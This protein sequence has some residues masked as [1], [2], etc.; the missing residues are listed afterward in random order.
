MKTNVEQTRPIKANTKPKITWKSLLLF[1]V[2]FFG[3][4]IVFGLIAGIIQ[5]ITGKNVVDLLFTGNIALLIDA[6]MFLIVFG[7]FKNIRSFILEACSF[8]PF[9]KIKT[10]VYL[11]ISIFILMVSQFVLIEVLKV[12]DISTQPERFGIGEAKAS[13]YQSL[14][15]FFAIAI[16]TPIKEEFLYRGLIHRFL[17]ERYHFLVGL[18]VSSIVFGLLHIG[19]PFSAAIMGLVFVGLFRLTK[20]LTVPIVLHMVWNLYAVILLLI[21]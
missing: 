14:I 15:L 20:S 18:F 7:I 19:Y 9:K 12:D 5:G 13:V 10:Y 21:A 17:E 1:I 3:L 4:S 16:I 2:S 11:L 8:Q 6:F